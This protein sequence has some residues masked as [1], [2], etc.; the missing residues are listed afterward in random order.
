MTE[1]ITPTPDHQLAEKKDAIIAHIR[2]SSFINTICIRRV[3]HIF[4]KTKRINPASSINGAAFHKR[5][6]S[7]TPL[8]NPPFQYI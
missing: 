3:Y 4:Y 5:L 1:D 8:K 7:V 2:L 6:R